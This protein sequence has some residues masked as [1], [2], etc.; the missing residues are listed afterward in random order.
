MTPPQVET[1]ALNIL[2][3]ASLEVLSL[4]ALHF[5]LKRKF[6]FS[7]AYLLAFVLENQFVNVQEPSDCL[8]RVSAAADSGSFWYVAESFAIGYKYK[9]TQML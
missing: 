7:P 5:A 2:G 6:G 3:Y 9:L 8:G 4:I 1:M